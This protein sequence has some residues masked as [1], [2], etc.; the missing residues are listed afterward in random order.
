MGVYF[1]VLNFGF[2]RQ[3]ILFLLRYF[4]IVF[5][6]GGGVKWVIMSQFLKTK[7]DKIKLSKKQVF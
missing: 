3:S 2:D 4:N 6:L 7:K 1:N 5:S